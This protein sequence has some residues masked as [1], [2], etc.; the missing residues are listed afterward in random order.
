MPPIELEY[1]TYGEIH[2]KGPAKK[3]ESRQVGAPFRIAHRRDYSSTHGPSEDSQGANG[4]SRKSTQLK[5]SETL[6]KVQ[7]GSLIADHHPTP[8]N[9]DSQT[10]THSGMR[11]DRPRT[12]ERT[13]HLLKWSRDNSILELARHSF[14][15][16]QDQTIDTSYRLSAQ[17]DM[18]CRAASQ[19]D[20]WRTVHVLGDQ[21]NASGSQS[22]EA[23]RVLRQELRSNNVNA[24][25]RAIRAWCMWSLSSGGTFGT[26]A[27]NTQLL[28]LV[29][30]I[31][32]DP[33]SALPLR[34]DALL[35]LSALAYRSKTSQRLQPI[36]R[37]WMR[38]RPTESSP[39]GQPLQ[40]ALF[41]SDP[42]PVPMTSPKNSMQTGR[43]LPSADSKVNELVSAN[44]N[45]YSSLHALPA[46]LTVH[47]PI[48]QSY[49]PTHLMTRPEQ[50][51][52]AL[53]T[54]KS[55][56]E[57][58]YLPSHRSG[59]PDTAFL[60]DNMLS[61]SPEAN[62]PSENA[63]LPIHS[64]P[65]ES[66]H[67]PVEE[68]QDRVEKVFY[69][70]REA[71]SNASVLYEALTYEGVESPLAVE[72]LHEAQES[73]NVLLNELSWA[74]TQIESQQSEQESLRAEAL[75]A[76]V[77]DAL[78]VLGE[79]L[80]LHSRLQPAEAI[81]DPSLHQD[82]NVEPDGLAAAVPSQKALG[83]RRAFERD[84]DLAAQVTN[85]E[86]RNA[87]SKGSAGVP[88]DDYLN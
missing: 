37:L 53:R 81:N 30:S 35:V 87:S 88:E 45:T 21:I 23:I 60:P 57:A 12:R 18:F 8:A 22:K 29:E 33:N 73:Q 64:V 51:L 44:G 86:L 27:A 72:F 19:P 62:H 24:Q 49:P 3:G 47:R 38:V 61:T 31:L 63:A 10:G 41:G 9:S 68:N 54:D 75:L 66:Q 2:E 32:E 16:N 7:Q 6:L 67:D 39:S 40:D 13:T 70:C 52:P 80:S 25:R 76:D 20:D 74:S 4:A 46:S 42:S 14:E 59:S 15:R 17:I 84:Y 65:M 28:A 5:R 48:S 1:P 79:A 69:E 82:E 34:Q 26:Y 36:A 55:D 78:S 50:Q 77:L 83:K 71:R 85:L 43:D 11:Q 58:L 56:S